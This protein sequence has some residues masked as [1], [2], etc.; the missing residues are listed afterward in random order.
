MDRRIGAQL[1][2]TRNQMKTIG[3]FEEGIKKLKGV[4]YQVVQISGIPLPAKEL[5]QVLDA[6]GME[7]AFTHRAFGDF[8]KDLAEIM[9]YNQT[10]GCDSAC[11]GSAPRDYLMSDDGVSRFIE[12]MNGIA[13]ILAQNG[14]FFGYHNH[15]FEF[16]KRNG[17]TIMERLLSESDPKKV[18]LVLDTYW[19][20]CGGVDPASFIRSVKGRAEFIHFK[21]Y[22]VSPEDLVERR[23]SEIG[24]GNLNWDDIIAACDEAGSRIALVEQDDC[25]G[26]DPYESLRM[27]YEFLKTKGFH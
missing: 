27:S 12:E 21:D 24:Y 23:F 10:L 7:C 2:T 18:Q 16:V 19:V 25:Y 8:Q 6:Y 20:Q 26:R 17:K 11:I 14:M 9:E 5:K 3:E 1:Y 13:D 22:A 4:G 15:C